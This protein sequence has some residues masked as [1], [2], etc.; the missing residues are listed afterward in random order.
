MLTKK[1]NRLT[2]SEIKRELCD[3]LEVRGAM[4]FI[5]GQKR[6]TYR[7]KYMKRGVP[8]IC[9]IWDQSPLFIE[10][11]KP[12]GRISKEQVDFMN[13]A[14]EKGA[15]CIVVESLNELIMALE[16]H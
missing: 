7:S 5:T 16:S 10:V 14:I 6:K 8:D 9:A 11:K 15:I 13:D 3:W 1:T 12:G 2:E 4:P